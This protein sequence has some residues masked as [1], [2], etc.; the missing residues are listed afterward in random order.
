MNEFLNSLSDRELAFLVHF[1][2]DSYLKRSQEI[3]LQHIEERGLSFADLESLRR[4]EAVIDDDFHERC[5][6]CASE[7]HITVNSIAHHTGRRIPFMAKDEKPVMACFKQ[8]TVCDFVIT[9]DNG[10]MSKPNF[11]N[12]KF[13]WFRS[14]W[15]KFF[16]GKR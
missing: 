4:Q 9:D 16:P 14:L 8:F 11:F 1:K 3:I 6:R 10:E 7:K 15:D 12:N 5:P 2:L 13:T